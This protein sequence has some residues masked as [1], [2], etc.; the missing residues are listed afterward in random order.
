MNPGSRDPFCFPL[1]R[2]YWTPLYLTVISH[3]LKICLLICSALNLISSLPNPSV[4]FGIPCIISQHTIHISFI[5]F[6]TEWLCVWCLLC[7]PERVALKAEPRCLGLHCALCKDLLH[8]WKREERRLAKVAAAFTQALCAV[9]ICA[10]VAL[11]R[12]KVSL[13]TFQHS[14]ASPSFIIFTA[15]S[16]ICH[17]LD[18]LLSPLLDNK[19]HGGWTIMLSE[20]I[21]KKE[22]KYRILMHTWTLGKKKPSM[23]DNIY[24][25]EIETQT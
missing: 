25:A 18:C 9:L 20:V 24:K 4:S 1:C 19:L 10:I 22:N 16:T 7:L 23:D 14:V 11:D 17:H 8:A 6:S 2:T 3:Y 13:S 21:Q 5:E 15:T 12:W